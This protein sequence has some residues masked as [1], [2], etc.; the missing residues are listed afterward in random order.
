MLSKTKLTLK[1]FTQKGAT[2]KTQGAKKDIASAT[3]ET[4]RALTNAN[5]NSAKMIKSICLNHQSAKIITNRLIIQRKLFI[6][7]I[8]IRISQFISILA[9]IQMLTKTALCKIINSMDNKYF[10]L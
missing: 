3:R 7:L 10:S 9:N 2:V 1:M 5:A 4:F 8:S 6:K